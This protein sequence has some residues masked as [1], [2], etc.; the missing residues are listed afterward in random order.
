MTADR[1][2]AGFSLV[3]LVIVIVIGGIL[4][5]MIAS[6]IG[7]PME[8]AVA[9]NRRAELVDAADTALRR[10]GRDVKRGLPNSV[11][12]AADGSRLEFV[13]VWESRAYRGEPGGVYTDAESVLDFG[14]GG[15]S[16]F[17]LLGR[18]LP[19]LTAAQL[20]RIRLVVY[21][22]NPDEF[23]RHA[24]VPPAAPAP[25]VISPSTASVVSIA[26][27]PPGDEYRVTLAAPAIFP[28]S[29]PQRRMFLVDGPVSFVC[30]LA[31]RTLLRFEGYAYAAAQPDLAALRAAATG[32]VLARDVRQC[33]FHY[34]PGTSSR[35]AL[36]GVDLTLANEAGEQV[37]LLRQVQLENS[38]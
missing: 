21:N 13:N 28:Y 11:R 33:A 20:S 15:D 6:F 1:R 16:Q 8:S 27:V 10:I 19:A 23:Y 30:D 31:N 18:P 36:L 17:N 37:R 7:R 5:A 4:A 24:A 34:L 14:A 2:Q 22:T 12:V 9:L 29:S 25:W 3:E 32:Q 35:A 26:P 38:P